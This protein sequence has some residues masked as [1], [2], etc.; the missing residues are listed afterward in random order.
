MLHLFFGNQETKQT[1]NLI[2]AFDTKIISFTCKWLQHLEGNFPGRG[3]LFYL[4]QTNQPAHGFSWAWLQK[5]MNGVRARLFFL[6]CTMWSFYSWLSLNGHLELVPAFLY[7]LYSTLYKT[8]IS[9][10]WTLSTGPKGVCLW[11]R[12]LYFKRHNIILL[13]KIKA[14]C[15]QSMKE[16]PSIKRKWKG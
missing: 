5:N 15:K 1:A 14:D 4:Q 16:H 2:I 3:M 10:R 12:W 6:L 9:L 7:C 13:F 8:D 11:E